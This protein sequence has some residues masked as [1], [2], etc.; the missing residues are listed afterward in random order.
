[1]NLVP[2]SG[3]PKTNTPLCFRQVKSSQ[4]PNIVVFVT[5]A[6]DQI[7]SLRE[8]WNVVSQREELQRDFADFRDAVRRIMT[9]TYACR[10]FKLAFE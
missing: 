4:S 7:N 3:L 8:S 10:S 5:K 9:L 1:M 6:E 2:L